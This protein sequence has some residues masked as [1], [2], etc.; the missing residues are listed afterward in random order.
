[1]G[2]NVAHSGTVVGILLDAR[3]RQSKPALRRALAAFGD[4]ESVQHFRVIGGGVREM[5]A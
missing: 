2:V 1:M 3:K 5:A 4:A